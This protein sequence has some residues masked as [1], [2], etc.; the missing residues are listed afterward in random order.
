[1]V[2]AASQGWKVE[3]E[4]P[5]IL[6]RARS[7]HKAY[8]TQRDMPTSQV[9]SYLEA[10]VAAGHAAPSVEIVS[11]QSPE[12]Q[13]QGDASGKRKADDARS[14]SEAQE[15]RRHAMAEYVV[16]ALNEELFIEL[17]EGFHWGK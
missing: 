1:M 17:L 14:R 8:T 3:L 13:E 12:Q 10:R 7:L 15:E 4:R 2:V 11:H 16:K 9:P 5:A 6:C